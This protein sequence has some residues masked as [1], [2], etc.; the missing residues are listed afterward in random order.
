MPPHKTTAMMR[1]NDNEKR[2]TVQWIISRHCITSCTSFHLCVCNVRPSVSNNAFTFTLLQTDWLSLPALSAHNNISAF[3]I[4][5]N[6]HVQCPQ[7]SYQQ[8][9]Q[10][11]LSGKLQDCSSTWSTFR[12]CG[13]GTNWRRTYVT[14]IQWSCGRTTKQH[15]P[16]QKYESFGNMTHN[17]KK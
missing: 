15:E 13:T 5:D 12:M 11:L 10:L 8:Q 4:T 14:R 7:F 9:Q 16:L 2:R 3:Y 1:N 17:V 6:I